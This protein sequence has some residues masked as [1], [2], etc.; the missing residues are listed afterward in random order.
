MLVRE[1]EIHESK[2]RAKQLESN[3]NNNYI[4]ND[5]YNKRNDYYTVFDDKKTLDKKIQSRH[6]NFANQSKY[7]PIAQIPY[8]LNNLP[9]K[10]NIL[11]TTSLSYGAYYNTNNKNTYY[12]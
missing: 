9:V 8:N 11:P 7:S 3:I 2:D 6:T 1:N 10:T 5:Y 4:T 12:Y